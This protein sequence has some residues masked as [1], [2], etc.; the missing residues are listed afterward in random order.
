MEI[1]KE[2]E[3][4]H[5]EHDAAG[6]EDLHQQISDTKQH[7]WIGTETSF[8]DAKLEMRS[9]K[10]AATLKAIIDSMEDEEENTY[11]RTEL[12]LTL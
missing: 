4:L 5:R 3:R 10:Q 1:F 8:R 2:A 12:E 9:A 6:I 7:L 11:R